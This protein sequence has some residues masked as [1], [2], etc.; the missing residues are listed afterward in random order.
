METE[1]QS[2]K[3]LRELRAFSSELADWLER[4]RIPH[5]YYGKI[6]VP[7]EDGR[8]QIVL[9]EEKSKPIRR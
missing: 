2:V 8:V 9:V 5:G 3:T 4:G 6:T 7:I 1:V